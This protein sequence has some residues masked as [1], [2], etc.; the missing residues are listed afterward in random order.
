MDAFWVGGYTGNPALF[1]LFDIALPDD[2]VII[3]INPLERPDL[4]L[5][6]QDIQNRIN[7]ISFNSSLLR[8]MRAISFVKRL[9]ADG[10]MDREQM[11]DPL[12]HMIADDG[13]MNALSVA[14]K[15]APS[16]YILA[17]LKEAGRS[18][19]SAF[20]SRHLDDLGHTD[21]VNLEE[22]FS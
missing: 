15:L 9:I 22:M 1:P 20:L 4:P 10:R 7:E 8:E 6:P 18:A 2:I 21:T 16:A 5:T 12:V 13:L 11:R 14:T 19:A 17:T 3:N